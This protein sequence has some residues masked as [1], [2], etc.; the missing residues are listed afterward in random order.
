MPNVRF[1]PIADIGAG[2][3]NR[4]M[5]ARLCCWI[6]LTTLVASPASALC[7]GAT[8]QQEFYE[9]DVVVR[10][11]LVSELNIWDDEPSASFRAQWG[12]SGNV[13]LYR[14]KVLETFKGKPGSRVRFFEERNSGA[15]YL[16]ADKEYLLFLNYIR[17]YSGRPAAAEGAVEVR[18][19]C[20]Q[21]K[22]WREVQLATL[23]AI[24]SLSAKGTR[25]K[26]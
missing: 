8:V 22:P 12:D 13:V 20:G 1:R 25:S 16:D 24:R 11:T 19:A 7:S 5:I 15:F 3:H 21:S 4:W 18:Y 10:A 9:A 26:R 14:L 17:P 2:M 23:K 6:A